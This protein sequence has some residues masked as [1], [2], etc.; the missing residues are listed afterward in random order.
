[1]SSDL[2]ELSGVAE[3]A[4]T[5]E[6]LATLPSDAPPAPWQAHARGVVWWTRPTRDARG[7]LTE[8][9][10]GALGPAV[11][12][13]LI[14]GAMLSYHD[15]PVGAY[16]EVLA[17]V[18]VRRGSSVFTHVPFIAVDSPASVVG[19][20]VNWALPKTLAEFDGAPR[21]HTTMRAT[22]QGWQVSATPVTYGPALPWVL[23][24]I[25][26]LVQT[27]LDGTRWSSRPRGHGTARLARVT[28]SA[29]AAPGLADLLP[30]GRFLGLLSDTLTGHLPTA[31]HSATV[32][33]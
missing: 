8:A 7:A 4:L 10:G 27:G 24:P 29:A 28:V 16:S 11:T 1:M 6:I 22:G 19:G 14:V 9:L 18:V 23:P 20:R 25:T 5:P 30:S 12:P 21:S 13:L 17:I 2:V 31:T 33:P 32:N 3:T 15:T 26:P